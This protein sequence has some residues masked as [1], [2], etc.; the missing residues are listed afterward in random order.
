MQLNNFE[1]NFQYWIYI[2]LLTQMIEK[3]KHVLQSPFARHRINSNNTA[4]SLGMCLT[5]CFLYFE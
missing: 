5:E 3:K 2:W 4:I 1:N